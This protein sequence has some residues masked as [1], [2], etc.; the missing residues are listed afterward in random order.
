MEMKMW[1]HMKE[2]VCTDWDLGPRASVLSQGWGR[3]WSY[4]HTEVR[5]SH[6]T[7]QSI[8]GPLHYKW[9]SPYKPRFSHPCWLSEFKHSFGLWSYVFSSGAVLLLSSSIKTWECFVARRLAGAKAGN[10]WLA[11]SGCYYRVSSSNKVFSHRI[12]VFVN[13]CVGN[14]IKPWTENL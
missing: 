2:Q 10:R 5:L 6:F 14:F 13:A 11:I 8:T 1:S 3:G 12:L 7:S 9:H 4:W